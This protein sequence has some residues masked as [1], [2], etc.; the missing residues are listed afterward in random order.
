M[1]GTLD[2][3]DSLDGGSGSDALFIDGD[4]SAGL[5]FAP[6]TMHDIDVIQLHRGNDYDLTLSGA[7]LPAGRLIIRGDHLGAGDTLTLD[8]AHAKGRL[9]I[10][11]GAGNGADCE[12]VMRPRRDDRG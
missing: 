12:A 4:Y 11:G 1:G 3:G 5:T 10:D 8:E 9:H 6:S 2:A 7:S